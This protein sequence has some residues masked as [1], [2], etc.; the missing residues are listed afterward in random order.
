MS[1]NE[2]V[3][4]FLSGDK[5]REELARVRAAHEQGLKAIVDNY[6]LLL[7]DR[8]QRIEELESILGAD[9][10]MYAL[11]KRWNFRFWRKNNG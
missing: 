5:I 6:E 11:C 1:K 8:D 4:T 7:R 10:S 9:L 2:T 3:L